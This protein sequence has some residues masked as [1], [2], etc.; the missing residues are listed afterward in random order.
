MNWLNKADVAKVDWDEYER[1]VQAYEDA[2]MTRG[3]AQG[4]V[5]AEMMQ[6]DGFN[7]SL[8]TV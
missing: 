6:E 5:E 8:R 7:K 2:G 3:D 4:V 1:R